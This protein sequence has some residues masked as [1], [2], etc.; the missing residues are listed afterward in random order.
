MRSLLLSFAAGTFG[1]SGAVV[2]QAPAAPAPA[3]PAPAAQAPA[4]DSAG[5][6]PVL[7]LEEAVSLARHNNPVH[8]QTLNNRNVAGAQLRSAYGAFLPNV[9][10]GFGAQYREGGGQFFNGVT[11]GASSPVISSSYDLTLTARYNASTLINPRL[12]RANVHAAD[13]D[14]K[15]SDQRLQAAVTQQYLAVL[16]QQ[17]QATLQDTLV[18]TVQ[19][20]LELARA[21]AAVGSATSLDVA[22]AEVALGQAQ[23]AALQARNQTEVEKVRLFQQMGVQQPANVQ[24]TSQFTVSEFTTPLNDLLALASRQNPTLNAARSRENVNGLALRNAQAAYTPTLTIQSG[25]GGFTNQYT[26]ESFVLDQALGNIQQP[27]FQAEQVKEIVGQPSNPAACEAL[28]LSPAQQ[29]ATLNA[30]NQFPFN[31][32]KNPWQIQ[33]YLSMPIFNGLTREQRVQEAAADRADARYAVRAQELALVADVT[34]AYLNLQTAARTATLQEQNARTARQALTL[35]EE[36]FRVGANTFLD[37]SQAQAD[38]GRAETDRINAVYDYH[39]AFAA[40]QSA[41]GAPL[42]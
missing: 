17:A 29:R 40:L 3:A 35:A 26:D 25:W 11:L 21:R 6:T 36:R 38:Y 31:F 37:V 4:R 24:L 27:C 5:P 10:A 42:R 12:Q 2:A 19:A 20:Q 33:A 28:A 7:T 32:T 22:R 30:N 18:A 41:V 13:A 34:N 9:D 16:R 39:R 14:A 23:V 15:G 8:L 1:I